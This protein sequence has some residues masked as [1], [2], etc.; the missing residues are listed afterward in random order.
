MQK[1]LK[2]RKTQ[3]KRGGG[4]SSDMKE[5]SVITELFAV[6][7]HWLLSDPGGNPFAAFSTSLFSMTKI[8]N[9]E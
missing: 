8:V 5:Q 4:G 9:S 6:L 2:R 7:S 3:K 1:F